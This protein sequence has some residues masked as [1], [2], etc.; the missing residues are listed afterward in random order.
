MVTRLHLAKLIAAAGAVSIAITCYAQAGPFGRGGQSG[1]NAGSFGGNSSPGWRSRDNQAQA[2]DRSASRDFGQQNNSS[3][4]SD[5]SGRTRERDDADAS[6]PDQSGAAQ[7]GDNSSD[8]SRSSS[9][10]NRR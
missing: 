7:T 4:I 10:I 9:S 6:R 8:R 1:G 5:D 2:P 3:D